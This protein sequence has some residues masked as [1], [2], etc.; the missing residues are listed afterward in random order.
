MIIYKCYQ[1][2]SRL[3]FWSAISMVLTYINSQALGENTLKHVIL[4]I[5]DL[6]K[7]KKLMLSTCRIERVKTVW[8]TMMNPLRGHMH[9]IGL[10]SHLKTEKSWEA[11]WICIADG[12]DHQRLWKG[13]VN[14]TYG[15]IKAFSQLVSTRDT[16]VIAGS[17]ELQELLQSQPPESIKYLAIHNTTKKVYSK[18]LYT[19]MDFQKV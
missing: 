5:K 8:C 13:Q 14:Q 11:I 12:C 2:S 7:I 18:S 9:F 15:V 17:W 4:I 19:I 3:P 6:R 1:K 16:L 10:V